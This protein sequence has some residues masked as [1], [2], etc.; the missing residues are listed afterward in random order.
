VVI[1][2]RAELLAA[3]ANEVGAAKIHLGQAAT[4]L[5]EN[6]VGVSASFSNGVIADGDI[7]IG[8]DGLHSFV[9]SWL[10]H[11]DRIRYSGYT[12]WRAVVPFDSTAVTPCETWGR[13]KRFG[14]LPVKGARVYWFATSNVPEG[15]GDSS[16]GLQAHLLS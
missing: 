13:G 1:L 11:N 7:L 15:G 2:H 9:R 14:M 16:E 3:L 4:N 6:P 12:S 8:A 5:E 10:R